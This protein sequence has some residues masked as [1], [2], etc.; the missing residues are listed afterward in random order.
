M[1][2]TL[3]VSLTNKTSA[4]H[5]VDKVTSSELQLLKSIDK[6]LVDAYVKIGLH[7]VI[8]TLVLIFG[9][10]AVVEYYAMRRRRI[11]R[12]VPGG[13]AAQ[14]PDL[15][16]ELQNEDIIL[17]ENLMCKTCSVKPRNVVHMPC[18]HSLFCD[19]CWDKLDFKVNC[20]RCEKPIAHSHKLFLT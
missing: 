8:G 20:G 1:L 12:G 2:C 15:A 10:L 18:K 3:K 11:I 4:V 7:S 17:A 9:S 5:V 14:L 6:D 16:N 19:E 13:A